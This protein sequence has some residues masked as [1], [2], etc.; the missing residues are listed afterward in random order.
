M[1]YPLLIAPVYLF[2]QQ[3]AQVYVGVHVINALVSAAAFPLLYL[4]GRRLFQTGRGWTAAVGFALGTLPSLVFYGEF[5]LTDV[6]LPVLLLL[7]LLCVHEMAAG[8]R[9][10][11]A[12]VA[13]G[14]VAGYAANTH[15]RGLVL[16]VILVAVVLLGTWRGWFTRW[17][18]IATG[19]GAGATYLAGYAINA[20]LE[21]RLF[22]GTGAFQ[23]N[24]RVFARLTSPSGA[25]RV[26]ADGLGQIWYLCAS[27]YGLAAIGL[28]I[29]VV[30]L[31]RREGPLA[32]RI[33]LGTALASNLGIAFATAT[34]IPDEGRIS[35]H[36]YGRYVA[37]FGGFWALVALITLARTVAR[38]AYR[39]AGLAVAILVGSL[40]VAWLYSRHL[41]PREA[42]VSFDAPEISFLSHDYRH[43][44]LLWIT[45]L[46]I[47][48]IAGFA[49]VLSGRPRLLLSGRT[50]PRSHRTVP[51]LLLCAL[52][53]VNLEAMRSI[54]NWIPAGSV[55]MQ[56]QPGPA[57]LIRDAHI[58]PGSSIVEAA[59]VPWKIN[60][61]H[62]REVY[63][64]RLAPFDP[65]GAPA[66]APTYA[67]SLGSWKGTDFGYSIDH[68]FTDPDK[69]VWVVWHRQ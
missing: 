52:T 68:I 53:L 27:T 28:A 47:V 54:T 32:T 37:L 21:R 26:L 57:E 46:T 49:F 5:A 69:T 62:Q 11:V 51:I 19:V 67:V 50:I 25:F 45:G 3:P 31:V 12:G 9:K 59:N 56:Y 1:G 33:V 58:P 30:V 6:L 18:A 22:P 34:A 61:R 43:A 38:R 65:T 14:V 40:G 42:F 20:W 66:G 63:W 15:V 39:L 64:E 17:S 24:D 55:T 13:A 2:V 41:W 7:L 16:L 35:N 23:P 29:A 10:V 36:F 8:S 60:Q 44:H 48:G 4:L